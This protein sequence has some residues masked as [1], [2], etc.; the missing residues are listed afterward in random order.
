MIDF[1]WVQSVSHFLWGCNRN[2][3]VCMLGYR[4]MV[5]MNG[6]VH[7]KESVR[8]CRL[9]P[10]LGR[11]MGGQG[12]VAFAHHKASAANLYAIKFF[13]S[14]KAFAVEKQA[15][16]NPELR[17]LMPPVTM[18]EDDRNTLAAATAH[19]PAPLN[20]RPL[21][22]AIVTEKGECLDEFVARSAPDRFTALQV[23]SLPR[24]L[25]PLVSM[26]LAGSIGVLRTTEQRFLKQYETEHGTHI[27]CC[28]LLK[29]NRSWT[30]KFRHFE[31]KFAW[32]RGRM[33]RSWFT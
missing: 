31:A 9:A 12:A 29:N 23:H 17:A 25:E 5:L 10:F 30:N 16:C 7:T 22:A 1:L 8:A 20:E 18:I 33:C 24:P 32:S 13:F 21:P 19:M 14:S 2:A 3:T 26:Y 11:R 28:Y 27:T 15:A 4:C 6:T